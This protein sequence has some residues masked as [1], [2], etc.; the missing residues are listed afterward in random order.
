MSSACSCLQKS[1]SASKP[2]LPYNTFVL[3]RTICNER[4]LLLCK[5][6]VLLG[7]ALVGYYLYLQQLYLVDEM[8]QGGGL[9][10]VPLSEQVTLR[11]V[12]PLRQEHLRDFVLHYSICKYVHEVQVVWPH[13]SAP[14]P[15][16]FFPYPHTH[17]KLSYLL[18]ALSAPSSVA[19]TTQ[20]SKGDPVT[21]TAATGAVRV[22]GGT[23]G[24]DTEGEQWAGNCGQ[25]TA[26]G[27]G[28]PPQT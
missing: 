11:V 12:A 25:G 18:S 4:V 8:L 15:E 1:G 23:A 6:A 22:L 17:A 20:S 2:D 19:G 21:I 5:L 13:A 3:L 24:A 9:Q 14:P 26:R 10:R 28:Q 16:E 7:S 27:S